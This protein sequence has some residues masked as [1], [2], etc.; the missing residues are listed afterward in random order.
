[1]TF[2]QKLREKLKSKLSREKLELLPSG[3][4]QIGDICILNL[5]S[6]LGQD[7]ELI[8]KA[9]LELF[10]RFETICNKTGNIK[11][12]FRKP[13]IEII[14]GNNN[15]ETIHLEAGNKFKFDVRKLMFAKGNINERQRLSNEVDKDEIIVDMFAGIGYFSI[16]I[17]NKSVKKLYS[18]ELNPE[19]VKYLKENKKINKLENM[20]IIEGDNREVI[21]KLVEKGVK[22]DRIVMGYLPPPFEYLDW[23][24]RISKKGTIIHF[25]DLISEVSDEE[26]KKDVERSFN[27]IKEYAY[28]NGKKIKLMK[29]NR[30]KNYKPKT[31]HYVLDLEVS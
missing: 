24:F 14:A 26:N 10:P 21:D 17:G 6:E 23:A 3:F 16:P 1:M 27:Q 28:K 12:K 25:E 22:A 20:E 31:G 8:G 9:V 11:G 29:V 30:V 7:K 19:A 5:K 18:I 13:Q 15:T 2:K 4:Q